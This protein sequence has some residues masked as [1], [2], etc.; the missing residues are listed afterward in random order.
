MLGNGENDWGFAPNPAR[1]RVPLTLIRY[2][3]AIAE[4]NCCIASRRREAGND[5]GFAPNPTREHVPLTL[6]TLSRSDSWGGTP[7][8]PFLH[9]KDNSWLFPLNPL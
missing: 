7:D 9:F 4:K 6:T 3:F 8:V 5:W 1:E 2:R